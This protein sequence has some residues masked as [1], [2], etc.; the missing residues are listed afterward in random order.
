MLSNERVEEVDMQQE[1]VDPNRNADYLYSKENSLRI[2]QETT[3]LTKHN[4]TKIEDNQKKRDY[5]FGE[6]ET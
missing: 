3:V 2:D 5:S 1:N 6:K 4:E